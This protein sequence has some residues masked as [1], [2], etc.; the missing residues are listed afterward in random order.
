MAQPRSQGELRAVSGDFKAGVAD[1]AM[2]GGVFVED[3]IGVV[4]VNEDFAGVGVGGE[5]SEQAVASGEGDVAHFAGGFVSAAGFEEF[6]I[7]PEC[8]VKKG[9][10]AGSRGLK[11][12]AGDFGDGRSEE[13]GFTALLEAKR[14]DGFERRQGAAK[15]G[16]QV[17]GKA[18]T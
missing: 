17:V 11:P 5:L 6:I 10:V 18:A 4:D 1:G 8:S 7:G 14:D 15:V 13:E 9:N 3:G 16:A 2:F 12:L